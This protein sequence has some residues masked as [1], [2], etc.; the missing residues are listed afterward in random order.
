MC[1]CNSHVKIFFSASVEA[2]EIEVAKE[3]VSSIRAEAFA[4]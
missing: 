3:D 1:S 4:E 2:L